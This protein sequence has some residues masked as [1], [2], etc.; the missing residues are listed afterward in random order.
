[1]RVFTFSLALVQAQSF[2]KERECTQEVSSF[3]GVRTIGDLG[4][5]LTLAGLGGACALVIDLVEYGRNQGQEDSP[6]RS[7][8]C[9]GGPTPFQ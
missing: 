2:H 9:E 3:H 7:N 6:N 8:F 4:A 1:M 5:G